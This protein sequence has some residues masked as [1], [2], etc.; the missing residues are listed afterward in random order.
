MNDPVVTVFAKSYKYTFK[1]WD[2]VPPH[3]QEKANILIAG[4]D[5]DTGKCLIDG[6]GFAG[7]NDGHTVVVICAKKLVE[8][9]R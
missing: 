9:A 6:F 8:P 4:I 2:K 7:K 3:L 5:S 1:S